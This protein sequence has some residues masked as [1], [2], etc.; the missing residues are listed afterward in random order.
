MIEELK[1]LRDKYLQKV[2]TYF[3]NHKNSSSQEFKFLW[4]NFMNISELIYIFE[5]YPYSYNIFLNYLNKKDNLSYFIY[6]EAYD[7]YVELLYQKIKVY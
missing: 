3:R 6:E 4:E 2:C 7:Y 5:D 1:N